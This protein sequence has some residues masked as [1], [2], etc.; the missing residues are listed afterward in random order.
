MKKYYSAARKGK[1]RRADPIARR[2]GQILPEAEGIK[3]EICE[4]SSGAPAGARPRTKSARVGSCPRRHEPTR[5][6]NFPSYYI[7]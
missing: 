3:I 6:F 5:G 4:Q 2:L 7:S 1:T